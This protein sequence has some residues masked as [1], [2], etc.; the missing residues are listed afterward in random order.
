M[1]AQWQLVEPVITVNGQPEALINVGLQPS[2]NFEEKSEPNSHCVT[3]ESAPL[4]LVTS[5]QPEPET[6][7][8]P[9][10]Q[11][12]RKTTNEKRNL[13]HHNLNH[14]WS[15]NFLQHLDEAVKLNGSRAMTGYIT[16]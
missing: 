5:T 12:E 1:F 10:T 9:I 15:I 14:A 13:C 6:F 16:V 11:V 2:N 4:V 3:V 7:V 8:E